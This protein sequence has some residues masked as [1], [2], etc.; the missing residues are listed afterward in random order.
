MRINEETVT[1]SGPN[2]FDSLE[3]PYNPS[4]LRIGRKAKFII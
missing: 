4:L 3:S 2:D 1:V